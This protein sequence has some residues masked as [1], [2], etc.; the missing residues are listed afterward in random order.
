MRQTCKNSKSRFDLVI[1]RYFC[2]SEPK[3]LFF[4][5]FNFV[6]SGRFYQQ[7]LETKATEQPDQQQHFSAA[8]QQKQHLGFRTS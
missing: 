5:C 4:K 6:A 1:N 2:M 3:D 8:R 7:K